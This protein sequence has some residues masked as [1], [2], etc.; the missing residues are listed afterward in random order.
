MF[1]RGYWELR[2]WALESPCWVPLSVW[3]PSLSL[4]VCVQQWFL[5][6][7]PSL[8]YFPIS[9][10]I[11][12]L[13]TVRARLTETAKTVLRCESSQSRRQQSP[14]LPPHQA[15]PRRT[16][17]S[18]LSPR[19]WPPAMTSPWPRRLTGSEWGWTAPAARTGHLPQ[20]ITQSQEARVQCL[21]T[22]SPLRV[23]MP[24]GP[25]YPPC[26]LRPRNALNLTPSATW[27]S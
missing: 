4:S 3:I 5:S 7:S 27:N 22:P 24:R 25:P 21:L 10:F 11:V 18:H 13:T 14:W 15:A 19:G 9:G 23:P 6:S 26:A 20:A 16:S 1:C 12:I 17:G 2:S 8:I